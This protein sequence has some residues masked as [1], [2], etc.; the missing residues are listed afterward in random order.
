MKTRLFGIFVILFLL[1][2][3]FVPGASAAPDLLSN[4][5]F[6]GG[7]LQ[8]GVAVTYEQKIPVNIV[9]IGCDQTMIDTGVVLDRLPATYTPVVR[10]PTL[11]KLKGRDLGLKFTFDYRT[12]F[13][14]CEV[15]NRFFNYLKQIGTPGDLA[16]FQKSYNQQEKNVLDVTGPVLYIDAPSVE[17][18]LSQNLAKGPGYTIVFVNWYSRPD[19]QFHVYE[20]TDEPDPDTRLNFGE[21]F[22]SRKMI[23]WGGSDSRLWFY[24]FSAGPEGW[25][26]NW[27]V[28]TP[29]L[30]GDGKEEY[31]MPPIWEY[32]AGGYRDPSLLSRDIGLIARFVGI[33][34]LFTTSPVFDPL[35]TAPGGGGDKIL[36]ITMLEDDPQSSG[37]DWIK[38]EFIRNT[39]AGFEPYYD[40]K[41]Q[42]T[43]INPIDAGAKRALQIYTGLL[44]EPDC[45]NTYG[46]RFAQFYCYFTANRNLYI[47]EPRSKDYVAGMFAFNS[48]SENLGDQNT[49]TTGF[50]DDNK[51]DGTQTYVYGYDTALYRERGSGFSNTAIHEY[52]HHFGMSHPHDGYDAEYGGFFSAIRNWYFVN[53]GDESDTVMSYTSL[54]NDFSQFDRDNLYR[55]EMAG[56]LNK[57]NGLLDDILA[58]P[59]AKKVSGNITDAEK[60]AG[61]A[62]ASFKTWNYLDA[63]ANARMA[64]VLVASSAA[65][66]GIQELSSVTML[67]APTTPAPVDVDTIRFP[68]N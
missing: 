51:V 39:F 10:R 2:Q 4:G 40:W 61:R 65:E 22:G 68:D 38:P 34:L 56:Y 58:H 26:N 41:V 27:N 60:Y 44:T 31:R 37:L 48:T 67:A 62:I 3:V 14:N 33:D 50:A 64:Y 42:V 23:A 18:W 28:D 55:W 19:F 32:T 43:D 15:S 1:S 12:T 30:D 17:K 8:P 24:D 36:N 29:D 52:G 11:Y 6:Q 59:R 16:Y 45:W 63:A 25:T 49:L 21:Y 5:A 20:K 54:S 9:F 46:D 7:P 53:S 47:P 57:A 35:V 13:A 66:L